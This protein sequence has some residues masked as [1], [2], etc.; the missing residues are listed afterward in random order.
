M[1]KAYITQS[2]RI[3]SVG[4]E[5]YSVVN[6]QTIVRAKPVSVAN[7]RTDA[8]MTQ[9]SQFLSAVRFYQRAN[10]RFFKFAFESKSQVES[11]Y[12][13]FMRLNAKLGGYITK[14]QGDSIG[15]PMIAP[16]II[17]Q[18]SLNGLR[19]SIYEDESASKCYLGVVI[20]PTFSGVAPATI[21]ALSELILANYSGVQESDIMTLVTIISSA[22]GSA[23]VND[24]DAEN[25]DNEL[26]WE[27]EQFIVDSTDERAI[28][29]VMTGVTC[30]V[31]SG[32]LVLACDMGSSAVA[33]G[34]ALVQS[35][36]TNKGTV[37]STTSIALN[38]VAEVAYSVLRS[39]IHRRQVLAWW[40]AQQQAILQGSIAQASAQ[41]D[42][43]L[44]VTNINERGLTPTAMVVQDSPKNGPVLEF[45]GDAS[46]VTAD[47]FYTDPANAGVTIGWEKQ[48][49]QYYITVAGSFSSPDDLPIN[50][51]FKSGQLVAVV[52]VS[53]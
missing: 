18:G 49:S 51:Y 3:G 36:N 29:E 38:E 30:V 24:L 6:G 37:V 34:C 39:R 5:T 48:G 47:D 42:S 33:S 7:P 40:G 32:A 10:Q 8:Q 45:N 35:R 20:A 41:A 23:Y 15:F 22:E 26:S 53:M 2:K 43:E 19:Q 9:R 46:G 13:A 28:S 1:A 21:G 50:V 17:S 14:A 27:V 44:L 31:R 52:I 4:G 11:D 12:N 16:W 25:I